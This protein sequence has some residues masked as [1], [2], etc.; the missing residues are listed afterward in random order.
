MHL[1]LVQ[2]QNLGDLDGGPPQPLRSGWKDTRRSA[3]HI[4]ESIIVRFEGYTGRY[5]FHCHMLEHAEH[6]MM[7]QFEVMPAEGAA[8][9]ATPP[10]AQIVCP[11]PTST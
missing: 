8:T 6:M 9:F 1:H 10:N 7:G 2:F 11:L 3:P 5:V 4:T